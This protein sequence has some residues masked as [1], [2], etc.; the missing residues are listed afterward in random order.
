MI[1]ARERGAGTNCRGLGISSAVDQPLEFLFGRGLGR[2]TDTSV[3]RKQ[4]VK[5]IRASRTLAW[6]RGKLNDAQ[7]PPLPSATVRH[8]VSEAATVP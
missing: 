1:T 4:L 8:Q 7:M 3:T 2:Q 5:A 6:R